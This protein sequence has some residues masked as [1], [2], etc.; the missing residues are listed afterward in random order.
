MLDKLHTCQKYS[1]VEY[2]FE[3]KITE[4]FCVL[5]VAE[6][7]FEGTKSNSKRKRDE[8]DSGVSNAE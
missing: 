4:K 5:T 7:C 8:K 6:S 1:M 3:S 2:T